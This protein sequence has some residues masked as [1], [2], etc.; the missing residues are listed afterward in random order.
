[1]K[2]K[3]KMRRFQLRRDEDETGV[4]GTGIVAEGIEF[5]NG[6]VAMTWYS[7]HRCVNVYESIKSVDALHGHEGKTV[8]VFLD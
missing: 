5:S 8:I 7:A 1:M 4:S 6:A 3:C 2:T